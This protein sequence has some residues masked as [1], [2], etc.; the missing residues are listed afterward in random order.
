VSGLFGC[1]SRLSTPEQNCIG[2]MAVEAE[3]RDF[4]RSAPAY[5]KELILVAR[6]S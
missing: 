5:G 3:Y 4:V 6:K 2:R 1:P